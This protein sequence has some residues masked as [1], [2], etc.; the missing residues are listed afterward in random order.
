VSIGRDG[1]FGNP[2]KIGI[3]GSRDQVISK[4]REWIVSQPE[5]VARI[6]RDLAGVVLGCYCTPE[7]C[8]GDVILEVLDG[9][10]P[11]A[12]EVPKNGCRCQGFYQPVDCPVHCP[13]LAYCDGSNSL[14]DGSAG[15]GVVLFYRDGRTVKI[16]DACG[17]GT[18]IVAELL[19]IERVLTEV[20]PSHPLIIRTDSLWSIQAL[21][22]K[23]WK[24]TKNLE[25]VERIQKKL[26]NR[27][28]TFEH[29]KGHSGEPGNEAA[30]ELASLGRKEDQK[31][32][33][34]KKEKQS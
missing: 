7:P 32:R 3:D 1:P 6:R 27:N 11:P 20:F 22:N 5:L 30:D 2:F 12:S 33:G 14:K 34:L 16:A 24:I 23:T 19:A 13:V 10:W 31:C 17:P 18:N 15:L 4:Y 25:L 28:V 9:K 26:K 21:T 8:H 29:V